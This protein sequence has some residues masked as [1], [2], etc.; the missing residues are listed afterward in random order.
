METTIQSRTRTFAIGDEQPFCIIG[1][2]IAE[3]VP[4]L[5]EQAQFVSG[6]LGHYDQRGAA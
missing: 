2:R 6:R 3:L 5:I 1:E 4:S